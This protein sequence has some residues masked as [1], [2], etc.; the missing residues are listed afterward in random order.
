LSARVVAQ[1]KVMFTYMYTRTILFWC[2]FMSLNA[3]K[4][5]DFCTAYLRLFINIC[6]IRG[7][8]S[9]GFGIY[10]YVN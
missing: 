9:H 6:L 10:V 1:K 4:V 8:C 7:I 5:I 2:T 3:L